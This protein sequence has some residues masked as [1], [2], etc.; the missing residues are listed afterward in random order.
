MPLAQPTAFPA[1]PGAWPAYLA[2]F[3]ASLDDA[4]ALLARLKDG[5]ART[6]AEVLDL[7]NDA[8]VAIATASSAAHLLAEVHPDAE[9]RAAAEEGAQAA[10]DLVTRRGL[11]H[12]LWQVLAATDPEGL[13]AG[14]ARVREHVLRD[15]RRAGVDRS[16]EDRERLRA[17]AQRCT[18]LGLEFARNIR[19]DVRTVRVRPEQLAGLPEDFLAEHPADDEGLVTLTTE[20][21]D[22][23]PVRTYATDPEVRLALTREHQRI[24]WPAN[25]AVLAELLRLRAERAALLGYPDWPTYDA[26]VKMI[27]SGRAIADLVERLDALTARAAAHDVDVML[28]RYRQDVPGATALTPADNLFYEQVVK[29]EQ[30]DV[31]AR[32]VREYFRYEAV[33]P[34]VLGV[35]ERLFGIALERV[36]A[37]TWH[38]D[39]EVYDVTDGGRPIGRV[40]LDMHPRAGKFNHAAQ[41]PLRPG[42][43]GRSLPEGALVCNFPTGL[44]EHDDVLTFFHELG[45]LVHEVLGG[46]QPWAMFSGVA[47]E[48]DFVEAP[49]QLLEEWG[50]DAGVLASFATNAA[51]E[52]IPA[53]LVE[54]MRRADAFARGAWTRR[55]LNFTA[56]SYGLHADP[57]AD[58]AAFTAGVDARFGPYT[59]VADSHQYAGFGHLDEYG[60]AYYTYLW[61]LVIAKDLRT[62]FTDGLMDPEVGRRY[63]EAIL[64]PGGSADAAELVERFLGRP[65]SFAAFEAWLAE[66]TA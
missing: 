39:V 38:A 50:W 37:P 55:Q 62:A 2:T 3:D 61:S 28:A 9:L 19:D 26:E 20:Y 40:Y 25:E 57:P 43:A 12:E 48:W 11:D 64:E 41:F 49:S 5:T 21:P 52:P 66:G 35:M 63:R 16:P 8:D 42:I 32:A 4:R 51:G 65:S 33:K 23:L 44:L 36:E 46:H 54:R 34:G 24:G 31:D 29:N 17:L 53:A 18:E 47:T 30:Y 45:H 27:G 6:A 58:L 14:A 22:L 13:D 10:E 56:L 1:E 7:W 60:S 59:P 15:F